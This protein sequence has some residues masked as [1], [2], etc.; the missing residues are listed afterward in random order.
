[1]NLVGCL[2]RRSSGEAIELHFGMWNKIMISALS[3]I[4]IYQV[5]CHISDIV[6]QSDDAGCFKLSHFVILFTDQA[7]CHADSQHAWWICE[8]HKKYNERL[9]KYVV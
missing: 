1:M 5:N 6:Q 7:A 3:E 9:V 8:S 2:E 4:M